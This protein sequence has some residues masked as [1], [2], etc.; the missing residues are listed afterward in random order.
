MGT[1]QEDPG[2]GRNGCQNIRS[3]LPCGSTVHPPLQVQD[4]GAHCLHACG[5]R[6]DTREVFQSFDKDDTK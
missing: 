6:G 1:L 3:I 4:M 2:E 5:P